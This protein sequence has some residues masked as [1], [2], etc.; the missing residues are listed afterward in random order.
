MKKIIFTTSLILSILTAP[1]LLWFGCSTPTDGDGKIKKMYWTQH[2]NGTIARADLDGSNVE[3][4]VTG[5]F[6]PIGIAL[7]VS[8]GKMY[9][10]GGQKIQRADLDG[11][12][13]EDLVTTTLVNPNGIALDL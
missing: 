10:T 7:D 13:V 6:M 3:E 12:N 11:S 4:L 9:W 2:G 8:G 5:L 1:I